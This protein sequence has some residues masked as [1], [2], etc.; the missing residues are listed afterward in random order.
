VKRTDLAGE[1][2]LELI[3]RA[4]RLG[5]PGYSRMTKDELADAI[6]R[7]RQKDNAARRKLGQ[8]G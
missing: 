3:N 7:M 2:R 4:R 6:E 8:P 1:T 5:I